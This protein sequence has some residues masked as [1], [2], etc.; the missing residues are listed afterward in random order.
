ML[1]TRYGG[2]GW[3]A[4]IKV[5]VNDEYG[6]LLSYGEEQNV[7]I[8]RKATEAI[9]ECRSQMTFNSRFVKHPANVRAVNIKMGFRGIYCEVEY[10]NGSKVDLMNNIQHLVLIG[11]KHGGIHNV[12]I[13]TI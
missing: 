4:R 13:N 11:H 6:F 9:I 5:V 10:K 2:T 12:G 8:P 7:P 3:F 1:I